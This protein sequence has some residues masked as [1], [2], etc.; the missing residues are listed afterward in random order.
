MIDGGYTG[1]LFLVNPS[2]DTVFGQN[3]Y[4]SVES[5]PQRL[6]LA[7]ICTKAADGAEDHRSLR[8][9]R[10]RNVIV[11]S[12]GFSETGHAAPRWN[13]RMLEIARCYNV[14]LLGPNCLGI[15][16]PEPPQRHLRPRIA[17]AGN[18]GLVSQSGAMCSAVL[19][20]AMPNKVG[21]SN[22]ISLGDDATSISAKSSTT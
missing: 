18:I 14:R 21:F 12:A 16:R 10:L 13:A 3:T 1:K 5:I 7:V 6:D 19:D 22:V 2:H 11:I 4:D 15:M 17:H 20:W 9:Q 8:P